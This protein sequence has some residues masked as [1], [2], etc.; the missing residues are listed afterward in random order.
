M[1]S[2]DKSKV[3]RKVYVKK[4]LTENPEFFKAFPHMQAIF[5]VDTEKEKLVDDPKYE[6]NM[7]IGFKDNTSEQ[8]YFDTLL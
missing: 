7:P 4:E 5:N 3:D 2:L 8:P 1:K 6:N